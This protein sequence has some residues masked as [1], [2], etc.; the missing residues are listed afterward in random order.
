MYSP[1]LPTVNMCSSSN[2]TM[3]ADAV[4]VAME[5]HRTDFCSFTTFTGR[6]DDDDVEPSTT[7]YDPQI[8]AV[9]ASA[10][11]AIHPNKHGRTPLRMV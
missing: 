10:L 9:V 3:T 1:T 4:A 11:P 8:L 2:R 6:R 7:I 5:A